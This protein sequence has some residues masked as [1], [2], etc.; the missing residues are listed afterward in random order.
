MLMLCS[1][2][3]AA[4]FRDLF[5]TSYDGCPKGLDFFREAPIK[6]S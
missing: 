6:E 2:A 5:A 3:I 1:D 4:G